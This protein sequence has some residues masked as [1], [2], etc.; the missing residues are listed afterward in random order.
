MDL[1][2]RRTSMSG[3]DSGGVQQAGIGLAERLAVPPPMR[4]R[5]GRVS[6]SAGCTWRKRSVIFSARRGAGRGG[7]E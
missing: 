3:G 4:S 5:D 1:A 7:Q 2:W 6:C